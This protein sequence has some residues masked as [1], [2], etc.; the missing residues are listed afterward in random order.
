MA[1]TVTAVRRILNDEPETLRLNGAMT[2]T[3]DETTTVD[4]TDTAK[5]AVGMR[6]E[7][8]D[9]G[10]SSAE[11]RKVISIDA[12]NNAFEA[13]RGYAG[14]TAATHAD[15]S[16]MLIAP[17]FPYDTVAQAINQVLDYD[18]FPHVYEIKEHQVTSNLPANGFAYNAPDAGCEKWLDVYQV[19]NSNDAPTRS[20]ITHT[21]YP[22]NVDTALWTTGKVFEIVGGKQDGTEKYYVNCVHRLAIGTLLARQERLVQVG[23]ARYLL[24]WTA[25]RRGAGP[26]AQSD[27]SVRPGYELQS[28]AYYTDLFYRLRANEAKYLSKQTPRRRYF[29]RGTTTYSGPS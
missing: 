22:Q 2:D 3:T 4:S 5:L 23:A 14:S 9:G 6:L 26:T 12:D 27:R 8:D 17:R 15:N 10:A 28:A 13:Y 20:G 21:V 18:L 19:V 1:A 29:V 7:H 25:P 24:E 16:F 11:Q